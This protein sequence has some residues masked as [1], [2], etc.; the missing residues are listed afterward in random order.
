VTAFRA[1]RF[2][3]AYELESSRFRFRDELGDPDLVHDLYLSTV[4]TAA[5]TGRLAEARELTHELVEVVAGLTPH[6]RLH[7]AAM[8]LEAEE[9]QGTWEAVT[10][11]EEATL[12]AV[13]QNRDTPCVR[14]ARSIL[15]CAIAREVQG[16]AERAAELEAVADDLQLEGH[17]VATSAPRARL[18]IARGRLDLLERLFAD[19][20]WRTRQSWFILPAAAARLDAM[21]VL[22]TAAD[23]ERAFAP[24][25]SYVE[26]FGMRALGLARGDETLLAA[27]DARFRALSLDWHAD[28]TAHLA[29]LRKQA[30]S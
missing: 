9:L 2:D 30:L 18:A 12:E 25:R 8:L 17:G 14:N 23:L 20:D 10:P 7:A 1:G 11:F 19:D 6:H 29:E 15:L 26:P 5:A 4:P 22:G 13:T 24:P 16:Q 3:E 21:A 27:A 28:Q